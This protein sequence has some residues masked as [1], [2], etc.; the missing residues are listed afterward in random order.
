MTA[1]RPTKASKADEGPVLVAAASIIGNILQGVR[2]Q[3]L[4]GQAAGLR[5]QAEHLLAVLR[6]WQVA[7][8]QLR[9]RSERQEQDI[10]RLR[11]EVARLRKEL[12]DSQVAAGAAAR[13]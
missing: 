9:I 12:A 3:N 6:E 2:T 1:R 8:S 11:G 10:Q 13:R 4:E 5:A 7:H